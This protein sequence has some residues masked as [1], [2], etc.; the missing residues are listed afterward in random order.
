MPSLP[1]CTSAQH[2]GLTPTSTTTSSPM[3]CSGAIF[4]GEPSPAVR[5]STAHAGDRIGAKHRTDSPDDREQHGQQRR[6]MVP[7]PKSDVDHAVVSLMMVP[8]P[9]GSPHPLR[10]SSQLMA[11]TDSEHY[12][13]LGRPIYQATQSIPNRATTIVPEIADLRRTPTRRCLRHLGCSSSADTSGEIHTGPHSAT[14]PPLSNS[15][16]R[17]DWVERRA[18]GGRRPDLTAGHRLGRTPRTPPPRTLK[19][20]ALG[21]NREGALHRHR[22]FKCSQRRERAQR[23]RSTTK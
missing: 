9:R 11:A 5:T 20:N 21:S 17:R 16:S 10:R 19:P 18:I 22:R 3:T 6:H 1:R 15:L 8:A 2:S 4:T 13:D 23:F 7:L 12:Q 14:F